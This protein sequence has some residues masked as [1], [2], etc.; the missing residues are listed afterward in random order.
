MLARAIKAQSTF[1][2][3]ADIVVDQHGRQIKNH[4]VRVVA[5]F[6]LVKDLT[7]FLRPTASVWDPHLQP[8]RPALWP[9]RIA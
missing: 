9:N 6:D 4:D 5:L 1:F 7:G 8:G 3:K 2:K